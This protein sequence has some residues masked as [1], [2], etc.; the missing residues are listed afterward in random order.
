MAAL[1][2]DV[3]GADAEF[4]GEQLDCRL[5]GLPFLGGAVT[6]IFKASP[7]HP[8]IWSRDDPGMTFTL[9]RPIVPVVRGSSNPF[10]LSSP[11]EFALRRWRKRWRERWRTG[12]WQEV[13]GT[14][15]SRNDP[16]PQPPETPRGRRFCHLLPLTATSRHEWLNSPSRIRTYNLAV[17]SRSLYR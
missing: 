17:N 13:A 14:G 1:D 3:L 5:V 11:Y 7:S 6:L 9:S 2:L 16:T 15:R 12:C 10:R 4:R 8:T